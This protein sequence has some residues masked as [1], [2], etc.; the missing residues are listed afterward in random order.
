ELGCEE[1]GCRQLF[2]SAGVLGTNQILLRARETGA[3]PDLNDAVGRGYGNNGDV[4]VSHRLK[5][6]DPAG[7]KQSLLGLINLD[8]RAD[9]ENPVYATMFSIPLPVE[10]YMLGYYVMVKTGDRA[11]ITYDRGS[12]S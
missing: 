7:T 3:L 6:T 4:M 8:G 10:T 2:L 1:I 9:P 5:D 11:A 12:D